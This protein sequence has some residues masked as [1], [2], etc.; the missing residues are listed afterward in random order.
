MSELE[1]VLASSSKIRRKIA[2][3][4][5]GV[6]C[7]FCNPNVDEQMLKKNFLGTFEDLPQYLAKQKALSIIQKFPTDYILGCDQICLINNKILEKPITKSKA[8]ENLKLLAGKIHQLIGG[9]HVQKDKKVI[10]SLKTIT[11]M[12]MKKLT[13]AEIKNYIELDDP[14]ESCGSYKFESNGYTLFDSVDGGVETINGLPFEMI[15]Q[16]LYE[17]ISNN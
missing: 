6:K 15:L 12:K 13:N 3:N 10:L 14:L 17:K 1:I 16:K 8:A 4:H 7:T 11:N 2:H 9:Y 5:S